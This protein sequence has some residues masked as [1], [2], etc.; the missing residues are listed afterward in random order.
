MQTLENDTNYAEIAIK[1]YRNQFSHT[2]DQLLILSQNLLKTSSFGM[3]TSSCIRVLLGI[4]AGKILY[5]WAGHRLPTQYSCTLSRFWVSAAATTRVYITA[6]DNSYLN[7]VSCYQ[8]RV[9]NV[10]ELKNRLLVVWYGMEVIVDSAVITSG[11]FHK[12][13]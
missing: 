12:V 4:V 6:S 9:Q 2:F 11:A 1:P 5:L 7:L 10:N 8:L 3:H 13:V